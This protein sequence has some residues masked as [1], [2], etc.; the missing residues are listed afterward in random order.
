MTHFVIEL[1]CHTL[2]WASTVLCSSLTGSVD[3][4]YVARIFVLVIFLQRGLAFS[5]VYHPFK[6][7]MHSIIHQS[8]C[9]AMPEY[10][11]KSCSE[12]GHSVKTGYVYPSALWPDT[13][14]C[15]IL[16]PCGQTLFWQ[17]TLLFEVDF[18]T[19]FEAMRLI[20]KPLL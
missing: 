17:C 18:E 9:I 19:V 3:R 16:L 6:G 1:C 15:F 2:W 8:M 7:T 12:E 20:L 14:L 11:R 4:L 5:H 10:Q 13:V